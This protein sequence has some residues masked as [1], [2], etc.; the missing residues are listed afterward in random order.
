MPLA[1]DPDDSTKPT[2]NSAANHPVSFGAAEFR[3]LKDKVNQ[4]FL[5]TGVDAPSGPDPTE[6]LVTTNGVGILTN[7]Q[8]NPVDAATIL[9]GFATVVDRT[10]KDNHT[11]AVM[12]TAI[13]SNN[14]VL[15]GDRGTFGIVTQAICQNGSLSNLIGGEL[16][17][18]NL[19]G[20]KGS[21]ALW[22]LN[23]VFKDRGDGDLTPAGGLSANRYNLNSVAIQIDSQQRGTAGEFC[24][25]SQGIVFSEWSMDAA[26]PGVRGYC[27]DTYAL[28][29]DGGVNPDT[30]F[31]VDAVI[32]MRSL[33]SILWYDG[34]NKVKMFFDP[35]V[36]RFKWTLNGIE[37]FSFDIGSGVPYVLGAPMIVP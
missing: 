20:N 14:N 24:G 31:R 16:A 10:G 21:E 35:S 25:W 33:Q 2:D 37:K 9:Y 34:V 15:T 8:H 3:A 11:V 12:A 13:A 32:R 4:L 22:G 30:A 18:A 28:H 23:L 27:L 19:N 7:V 36:G 5:L 1:P 26:L 17:V 29:Y 6:K